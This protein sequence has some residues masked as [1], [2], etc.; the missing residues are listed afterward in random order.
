MLNSSHLPS[1]FTVCTQQNGTAVPH[2]RW[3]TKHWVTLFLQIDRCIP[4]L[5]K[6]KPAPHSQYVIFSVQLKIP[7]T[8]HSATSESHSQKSEHATK[9]VWR[10]REQQWLH[11]RCARTLY[12]SLWS[13][14]HSHV[15]LERSQHQVPTGLEA[16]NTS[17]GYCRI[18][19]R[20]RKLHW[21]QAVIFLPHSVSLHSRKW[22]SIPKYYL[23]RHQYYYFF[24]LITNPVKG[25]ETTT[26]LQI[27]TAHSPKFLLHYNY[28]NIHYLWGLNFQHFYG[29]LIISY[30]PLFHSH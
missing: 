22:L 20:L 9:R 2:Y 21:R 5:T 12:R 13:E 15:P 14:A 25:L 16:E 27:N 24:F 18:S 8:W 4:A 6:N 3:A 19:N 11:A 26:D 17:L 29:L 7:F 28:A 10:C 23:G 1:W 30:F